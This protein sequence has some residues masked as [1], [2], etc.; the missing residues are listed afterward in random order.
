MQHSA[1]VSGAQHGGQTVLPVRSVPRRFRHPAGAMH[2]YHGVV[3]R[4]PCAA[5]YVLVLF[6]SHQLVLLYPFTFSIQSPNLLPW[7]YY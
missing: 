5:L 2:G 6:C 1:S 4:T 3:G 7:G